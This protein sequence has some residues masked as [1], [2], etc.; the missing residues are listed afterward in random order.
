MRPAPL[1][2]L[3]AALASTTTAEAWRMAGPAAGVAAAVGKGGGSTSRAIASRREGRAPVRMQLGPV[4]SAGRAFQG[5][6]VG[7]LDPREAARP[8][9]EVRPCVYES[10]FDTTHTYARTHAPQ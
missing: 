3:A 1:L 7:F 9:L 4:T 10:I 6:S 5:D 2:W 8:S